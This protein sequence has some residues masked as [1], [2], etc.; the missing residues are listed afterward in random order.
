MTLKDY[1]E[2]NKIHKNKLADSIG[3]DRSSVYNYLNGRPPRVD[4]AIK[5]KNAAGMSDAEFFDIFSKNC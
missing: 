5:I 3:I 4:V 1:F 2:K